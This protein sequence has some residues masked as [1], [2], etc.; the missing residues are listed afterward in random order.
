VRRTSAVLGLSTVLIASTAPALA[1]TSTPTGCDK[2]AL[3]SWGPSQSTVAPLERV[4]VTLLVTGPVASA[5]ATL[6]TTDG[7]VVPTTDPLYRRV[8]N[9]GAG[10]RRYLTWNLY[11]VNTLSLEFRPAQSDRAPCNGPRA[12]GFLDVGTV[13]VQR[14]PGV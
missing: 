6:Q 2:P 1:Q 9:V 3:Q 7:E 12:S 14:S 13:R 11:P 5:D 8:D 10:K 4:V